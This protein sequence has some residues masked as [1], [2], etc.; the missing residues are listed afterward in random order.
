MVTGD[1]LWMRQPDGSVHAIAFTDVVG[2][3]MQGP[4]RVV[5]GRDNCFLPVLPDLFAGIGPAVAAIDTAVP[6]QLRF[7]ASAFRS[8]D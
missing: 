2:V 4:G 6:A 8:A 1:G 7:P 3:E 5:Y